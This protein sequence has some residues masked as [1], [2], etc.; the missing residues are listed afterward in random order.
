MAV[1]EKNMMEKP[2]TIPRRGS[3][4]LS[5]CHRLHSGYGGGGVRMSPNVTHA[6]GCPAAR[7]TMTYKF[8]AMGVRSAGPSRASSMTPALPIRRR[9]PPPS[10]GWPCRSCPTI[11]TI[12]E[13]MGTN[14]ED[15]RSSTMRA[16]VNPIE[17]AKQKGQGTRH[18]AEPPA[19]TWNYPSSAG[20]ASRRSSPATA[21]AEARRRG[22]ARSF[23]STLPAPPW[24]S[25]AS[26]PSAASPPG[27]S[28]AGEQ[29]D[30][31]YRHRGDYHQR[32]RHRRAKN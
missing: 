14:A 1:D 20:R 2:C 13:D 12:G 9:P 11:Y 31:R 23:R 22:R 3:R 10:A 6:R 24:W 17:M 5:W 27:T 7:R 16:G 4:R 21:I 32:R 25:R 29:G 30:R 8:A 26:A 15:V 19:R 28:P 18:Y